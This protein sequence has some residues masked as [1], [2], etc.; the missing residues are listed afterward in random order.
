MK[1]EEVAVDI[2]KDLAHR[3]LLFKKEKYEHSYPHCWRCKTPIA[4]LCPRQ[5]VYRHV[6]IAR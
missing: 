3:G 5:L 1:D 4:V 6:K 2:I